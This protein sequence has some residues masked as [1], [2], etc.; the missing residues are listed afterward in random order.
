MPD[1]SDTRRRVS[2]FLARRAM[3]GAGFEAFPIK[4]TSA[5]VYINNIANYS[6]YNANIPW[7]NAKPVETGP[8]PPDIMFARAKNHLVANLEGIRCLVLSHDSA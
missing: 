7:V 8:C 3:L 2:P 6:R 1:L 5:V 4:S